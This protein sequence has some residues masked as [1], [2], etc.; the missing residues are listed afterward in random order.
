MSTGKLHIWAETTAE[1]L[2]VEDITPPVTFDYSGVSREDFMGSM[3]AYL[4]TYAPGLQYTTI[5][6]NIL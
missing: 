3:E 1:G 6:Y 4:F 5:E 2:V